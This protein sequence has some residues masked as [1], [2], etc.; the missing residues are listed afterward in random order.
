MAE[1]DRQ[2][3]DVIVV[4]MDM[5]VLQ[6][7][8]RHP[9]NTDRATRRS[10]AELRRNRAMFTVLHFILTYPKFS[11]SLFVLF[12]SLTT[13]LPTSYEQVW[14]P[15]SSLQVLVQTEARL[16]HECVVEGFRQ[17]DVRM[18]RA[19]A[20]EQK[21]SYD[22]HTNVV[23]PNL[24]TAAVA[25]A[26]C[27]NATLSAQRAL[28]EY[29][30]LG[31][32]I[33][34]TYNATTPPSSTSTTAV[35]SSLDQERLAQ[36]LLGDATIV[37]TSVSRIYDAYTDA[38]LASMR[39]VVRYSH[40]RGAYDYNYFIG[41]KLP[42]LMTT[43]DQFNV[44]NIG[45]TFPEQ[46]LLLEFRLLLS[47][48]VEALNLAYNHID[49][50]R[51]RL[52]EFNTSL[53]Q[54]H[55]NYADLF[56]RFEG[57]KIYSAEFFPNGLPVQFSTPNL[58]LPDAMLP[59]AFSIPAITLPNI[60][61]LVSEYLTQAARLVARFLQDAADEA[62]EQTRRIVQ[63]LLALL[64]Q[65]V[66]LNDYYPPQYPR[67]LGSDSPDS[68]LS[69]LERLATSAKQDA[70]MA[71]DELK[72]RSDDLQNYKPI[73]PE[74]NVV[75]PSL[76][77]RDKTLFS[78]LD[79]RYPSWALPVWLLIVLG[80]LGS[81]TFLIECVMQAVRL[82]RLKKKYE[83]KATP[84]L[85]EIDFAEEEDGGGEKGRNVDGPTKVQVAQAMLLKHAMNPWVICCLCIAPA[86]LA[87]LLLWFPHVK[88][89]C[90]DSRRG[91]FLARN[92]F[93]QIQVNNAN[94]QGYAVHSIAQ[95][96]C[97]SRQRSLCDAMSSQADASFRHD[98]AKLLSLKASYNE[99]NAA[100]GTLQRC[101][102]MQ[103]LDAQLETHCC[104]L[105]GY[106]TNDCGRADQLRQFCPIDHRSTPA[107]TFQ[108]IGLLLSEPW[109]EIDLEDINIAE[110]Q[111]NCSVIKES[112]HNVPCSG[113]DADLIEQMSIDADCSVQIYAIQWCI[114]VA[115]AI[116]HAVMINWGN[117]L[118]F[119]GVIQ[120]QW[121]RLKPQGIKMITH[122]NLN[123]DLI[124]GG[125]LK[126]RFDRVD[127]AMRRYVLSGYLQMGLSALV[128]VVW[129]ATFFI[130]RKAASRLS[131]Y[132]T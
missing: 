33:P 103:S 116:F 6:S 56:T 101:V 129:L 95:Q 48:L 53:H 82:Y 122:V 118:M 57:L 29:D 114:F 67:S 9:S 99:S 5:Q 47:G 17:H 70:T 14:Q 52:A 98:A 126:E 22:Y 93:T 106:T 49:A 13:P 77:E 54:L 75:P 27:F 3:D 15:F 28:Q 42:L 39:K 1:Q 74:V 123:G 55:L 16:Y 102:D 19:A 51:M 38:S 132:H 20:A 32:F 112:C 81:H 113:V 107:S 24:S 43:I 36:L 100:R 73:A 85:P 88:R 41:V 26:S 65:L 124:K 8:S 7:T 58:S 84:D 125:D 78:F 121:K 97:Y 127:Q 40:E 59:P 89:N 30:A 71:L 45:L 87:V 34:R 105:E 31:L 94:A 115:L 120:V 131:M 76:E 18:D 62:S 109:C 111:F 130:L 46:R 119:N 37:Q 68:E 91:T 35:C 64:Q 92:I 83:A 69:N 61:G 44:P 104:G 21:R 110:A 2:A 4:E 60:D 11:I 96:S 80:Y 25:A 79:V 90:I 63:E 72:R 108:P 86:V 128:F 66:L 50:L 12:A 23:Q 10:E 117:T